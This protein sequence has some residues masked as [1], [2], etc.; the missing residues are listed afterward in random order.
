M[1]IN[2]QDIKI[3]KVNSTED[4]LFGEICELLEESFIPDSRREYNQDLLSKENFNLRAAIY[5][6]EFVGF[7]TQWEFENFIYNEHAA[8]KAAYRGQGMGSIIYKKTFDLYP[9]MLF[10]SEVERPDTEIASRRIE[11]NRRLGCHL[12]LYDYIQP[13]YSEGKSFVPMYINSFPR[14]VTEEE[15]YQIK[16]ILYENVYNY[17]E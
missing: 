4:S 11:Y 5:K 7:R 6:D 14:P 10:V 1:S 17:F 2:P 12:N 15:Y 16:K 3:V 9:G 8:V 13:P